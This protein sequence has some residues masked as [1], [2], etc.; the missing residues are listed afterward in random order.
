MEA[1]RRSSRQQEYGR[2]WCGNG[3]AA[4]EYVYEQIAGR[5]RQIRQT[6]Y[7]S[8]E[9]TD[10]REY[11]Y[12]AG[13]YKIL[14]KRTQYRADGTIYEYTI[15]EYNAA[16][17]LTGTKSVFY[18]SDGTTVKEYLVWEYDEAGYQIYGT[19]YNGSGTEKGRIF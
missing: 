7:S 12:D 2:A 11:G 4:D 1:G 6:Q 3:R 13:G 9:E 16:G 5:D 14:E 8:D 18:Q 10:S 19:N 17:N 15:N